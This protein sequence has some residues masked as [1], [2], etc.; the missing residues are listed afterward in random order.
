M[1]EGT[2]RQKKIRIAKG[3]RVVCIGK[4]LKDPLCRFH[5]DPLPSYVRTQGEDLS[6]NRLDL[7]QQLISKH[8]CCFQEIAEMCFEALQKKL[9]GR[10][11][12]DESLCGWS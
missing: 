6:S 11:F 10:R 5:S 9:F 8:C 3:H 12:L 1:K 7:H 2:S 4:D